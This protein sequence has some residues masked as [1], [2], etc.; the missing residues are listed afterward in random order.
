MFCLK[1]VIWIISC[2]SSD[3]FVILINGVVSNLLKLEREI[4]QGFQLSPLLFPLVE[5]GPSR[6]LKEI[7]TSGNF[8]GIYVGNTHNV[9]DLPFVD[10]ILIFYDNT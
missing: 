2:I 8:K 4:M 3:S 6:S 10:E 7:S 5:K 9:S 1:F